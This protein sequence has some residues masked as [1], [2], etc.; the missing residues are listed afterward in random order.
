M[1]SH[2]RNARAAD[3]KNVYKLE[4][5]KAVSILKV[6]V[7]NFSVSSQ[8]PISFI[9]GSNYFA[10]FPQCEEAGRLLKNNRRIH[11]Y[12]N[13]IVFWLAWIRTISCYST[14][15]VHSLL[16]ATINIIFSIIFD[17]I[18]W[19]TTVKTEIWWFF[20]LWKVCWQSFSVTPEDLDDWRG[21]S[22]KTM[23]LLN[24]CAQTLHVLSTAAQSLTLPHLTLK[25]RVRRAC[26]QAMRHL[27]VS[28]AQQKSCHVSTV[29]QK[30]K[31]NSVN[32][33]NWCQSA[34]SFHRKNRSC[35]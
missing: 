15:L 22:L 7:L 33:I 1:S 10:R 29:C 17:D 28:V 23:H 8:I 25:L 12:Y 35:D 13:K 20:F 14:S 19:K 27:Q 18:S 16:R 9:N 2:V 11:Y 4:W 24:R 26:Q 5:S 30:H 3:S 21:N 32:N 34:S 6:E 31:T